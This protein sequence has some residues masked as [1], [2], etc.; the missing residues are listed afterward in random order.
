M[1]TTEFATLKE[2]YLKVDNKPVPTVLEEG[3]KQ[4]YIG[5]FTVESAV[6]DVLGVVKEAVDLKAKCK[7][8]L[9]NPDMKEAEEF[10]KGC[11]EM[12]EIDEK[13]ATK[14]EKLYELC[15]KKD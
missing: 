11:I 6:N 1:N 15:A 7:E 4:Q 5:D 14:I 3:R 8:M 2:A 9:D 13:C 10:L 12:K